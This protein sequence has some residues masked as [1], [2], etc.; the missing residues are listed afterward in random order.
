MR[1]SHVAHN[2]RVQN[3]HEAD[4][5]ER[6]LS[7]YAKSNKYVDPGE[8]PRQVAHMKEGVV[9]RTRRCLRHP[10]YDPDSTRGLSS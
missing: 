1:D 9:C 10:R 5:F 4:S 3:S 6:V 2:L 8:L 7:A